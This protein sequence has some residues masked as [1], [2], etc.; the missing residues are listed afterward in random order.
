MPNGKTYTNYDNFRSSQA[1]N[2]MRQY[3]AAQTE[4]Q[5]NAEK[6]QDMRVSY[7]ESRSIALGKRIASAEITL[8]HE[9][10][11]LKKMLSDIYK[12]ELKN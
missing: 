7:H 9:R 3:V 8:D 12:L 1:R 11:S 5:E 10:E 6:L 2:M 4:Y